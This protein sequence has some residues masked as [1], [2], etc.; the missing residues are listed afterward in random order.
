VIIGDL[1][2]R[3]IRVKRGSNRA[4]GSTTD[5]KRENELGAVRSWS[6]RPSFNGKGDS[7]QTQLTESEDR[8]QAWPLAALDEYLR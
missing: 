4:E 1:G 7:W 6:V 3:T 2:G 5:A 8:V